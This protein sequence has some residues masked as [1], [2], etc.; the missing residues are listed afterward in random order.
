VTP[1]W[2]PNPFSVMAEA[3]TSTG[4]VNFRTMARSSREIVLRLKTPPAVTSSWVR[5]VFSTPTPTSLGSKLTCVTQLA[6]MPLRRSP[7][8][9]PST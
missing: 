3:S 2:N 7:S 1:S 8:R 4:L 9:L 6:V 5:A